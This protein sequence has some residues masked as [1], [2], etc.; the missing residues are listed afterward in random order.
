MKI[1]TLLFALLTCAVTASAQAIFRVGVRGGLNRVLTTEDAASTSGTR[2]FFNYSADKSSVF[3]WQAGLV[4][5]A[6]FGKLAIQ[7]AL[8]FSQKGEQFKNTVILDGIAR[9][10]YEHIGTNRYNWAELPLNV[11]YTLHGDHGLQ[12]F[13][14]PYLA[15]AVGGQ[16]SGTTTITAQNPQDFDTKITYGQGT[17]NQRLDTG[18]NFGI[19]YRQGP[20]QMQLGYGIGLRNL[21]QA[22]PPT[23]DPGFAPYTHNFNADAAYNRV[24]QLTA[25]YFF[26]L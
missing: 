8:V 15:L 12:V 1:A 17:N 21:H 7:P 16:Q 9:T 13:A 5:E 2:P 22:S 20:L 10:T 19:G 24:A 25:T 11:V 14:G 3:A 4:A 6:S 18:F 26:S 23:I